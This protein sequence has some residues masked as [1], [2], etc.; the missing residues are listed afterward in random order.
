MSKAIK[1]KI[2]KMMM[3]AVVGYGGETWP[4]TEMDM[5]S[6]NAW[7]RKILRTMYGPVVVR[8]TRNM[9]NKN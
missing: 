8:S 4:V 2:C 9:E 6:L 1:T 3:K 5:R 7:E